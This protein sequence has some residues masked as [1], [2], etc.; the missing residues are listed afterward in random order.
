MSSMPLKVGF[1]INPY[2]GSGGRTGEKGSDRKRTTNPETEGRITR[3]FNTAPKYPVYFTP[4]LNMG[5][6][7]LRKNGV[8]YRIIDAGGNETTPED[9]KKSVRLM[10][11]ENVSIIVF[12]GGDGTAKD[13]WSTIEEIGIDVPILGIPTGV[14]MHSGVFAESPEAAG[15]LLAHFLE[16]KTMEESTD[17]MDVDE[18]LYK[19]GIYKVVSFY[20]ALTVRFGQLSVPPK[21]EVPLDDVEGAVDFVVDN[22]KDSAFYVMG[23]GRTV[24]EI[25]RKLGYNDI[26]YLSVDLFLGRR[27]LKKGVSYLDLLEMTKRREVFIVLTPIGG[28]GFIFGRGNQEI[29]PE[30]IKRASWSNVIVL[31]S[32]SKIKGIPCLRVDTGDPMIDRTLNIVKV[33]VGYNEY[34]SVGVCNKYNHP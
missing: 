24:K 26:N 20:K 5:E 7:F 17:I 32:Y 9:T 30:I 19:E 28:Q 11:K 23:T 2:A 31:S 18:V 21:S 1:L 22:I 27:L 6:I 14:K 10:I 12:A 34:F 4:R 16:G 29:G 3:F 13:V 33:I 25:E 8:N 15:L